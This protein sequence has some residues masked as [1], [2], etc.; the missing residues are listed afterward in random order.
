MT[1]IIYPVQGAWIWG[2]GWLSELSFFDF[3][4]STVVHSVGGWAA[5]TGAIILGPR[6]G[7]YDENGDVQTFNGS[8]LPL[9]SLGTFILW[10]GWLGFNGG[11]LPSLTSAEDA[12][13]L[14][15]IYTNTTM[16][17]SG[18]ILASIILSQLLTKRIDVTIVLNGALA[19]LVS[20]TANPLTP[21]IGQ[22]VL[23]GAVGGTIIVITI[24]LMDKFKIDDVV[25][26]IPVHLFAGIW[27]TL[28]ASFTHPEVHLLTQLV[29]I[30]AIGIFTATAS[31][32]TWFALKY[33]I[34]IRLSKGEEMLGLDRVELGTPAYPEFRIG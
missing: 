2:G 14:A 17:A 10:L 8:S 7:K 20:I 11:S 5:I 3:A 31:A 33:T 34:G 25:G 1:A 18:G 32:A 12:V 19:G 26:A 29:G 16:A 9:V 30:S 21:D 23:I 13:Q 24:P 28:A 4:G 22:A 15:I 6:R 27:G